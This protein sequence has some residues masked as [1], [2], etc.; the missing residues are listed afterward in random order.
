MSNPTINLAAILTP[1]EQER[2]LVIYG[3]HD[4]PHRLLKTE[5]ILPA[6]DRI[7]AATGQEN[8]PD[9][10]AYLLEYLLSRS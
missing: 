6:M 9:Y 8:D 3:S 7:N 1:R 5:I 2:A 10:M 4:L